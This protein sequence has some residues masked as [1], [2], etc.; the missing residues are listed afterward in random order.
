HLKCH[1]R[2]VCLMEEVRGCGFVVV[3]LQVRF[4][5]ECL[6]LVSLRAL[7][8]GLVQLRVSHGEQIRHNLVDVERIVLYVRSL[9]ADL[10][11]SVLEHLEDSGCFERILS[12][13]HGPVCR[14][15]RTPY[16]SPIS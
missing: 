10:Q 12:V 14:P 5:F 6:P 8:D 16:S 15:S 3:T 11:I 1:I 9:R 7:Q 13:D 2:C 4:P